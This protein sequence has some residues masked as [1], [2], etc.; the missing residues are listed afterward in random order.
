MC[1]FLHTVPAEVLAM[2]FQRAAWYERCMDSVERMDTQLE[3]LAAKLA[4]P[5]MERL[6][7]TRCGKKWV[8]VEAVH[9]FT[10]CK[11][12]ESQGGW[13][14]STARGRA[15][16]RFKVVLL[17]SSVEF[18]CVAWYL[19]TIHSN[20]PSG[21]AM[22]FHWHCHGRFCVLCCIGIIGIVVMALRIQ[23]V[24]AAACPYKQLGIF[25]DQCLWMTTRY[26]FGSHV[27]QVG[28]QK[29]TQIL[30]KT[31]KWTDPSTQ[32]QCLNPHTESQIMVLLP[33][34]AHQQMVP[35]TRPRTDITKQFVWVLFR[36]SGHEML[37]LCFSRS[38]ALE[39]SS[40]K[41]PVSKLGIE[42]DS[43]DLLCRFFELNRIKVPL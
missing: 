10:F 40:A 38:R 8:A 25:W 19:Y 29:P 7:V 43:T 11:M 9:C 3:Q 42:N 36:V 21:R 24:A 37:T 32:N 41:V 28:R 16:L 39:W 31:L 18:I 22:C 1:V 35:P 27:V 20:V 17:L 34:N 33:K 23:H 12:F 4:F 26:V 5:R 14:R 30:R 15:L 13:W 2:Q 6:G